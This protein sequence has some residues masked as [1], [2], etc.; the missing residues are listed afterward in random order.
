[1]ERDGIDDVPSAETGNDGIESTIRQIEFDVVADSSAD[2]ERD[3]IDD[4]QSAVTG[5]DGIESTIRQIEFDVV[6]N[7]HLSCSTRIFK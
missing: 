5:S 3:G 6:A 2:M 4:A 7:D 1:M